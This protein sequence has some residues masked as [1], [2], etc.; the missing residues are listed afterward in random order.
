MKK[1]LKNF[2]TLRP[3]RDY[4]ITNKNATIAA[5]A[6]FITQ[7]LDFITT[8]YG[9]THTTAQEANPLLTST[10]NSSILTFLLIKIFG[11]L[12]LVYFTWRRPIAPF[13]V[14]AIYALVVINNLIVI[15]LA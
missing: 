6:I 2:F 4:N 8:W 11:T 15:S 5:L 10:V 13:V 7:T 9:T 12:T 1:I 3:Q 14:T